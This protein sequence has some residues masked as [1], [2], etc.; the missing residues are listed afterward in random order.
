PAKWGCFWSCVKEFAVPGVFHRRARSPDQFFRLWPVHSGCVNIAPANGIWLR[1]SGRL[2][3]HCPSTLLSPVRALFRPC[4]IV[5][6]AG[7]FY[8]FLPAGPATSARWLCI[9]L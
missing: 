5:S 3:C 6:S 9:H 2:P 4:L 8:H 7:Q 1:H